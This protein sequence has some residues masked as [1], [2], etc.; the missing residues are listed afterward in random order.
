MRHPATAAHNLV[1]HHRYVRCGTA[2]AN[3]SKLEKQQRQL[4]QRSLASLISRTT[5][6]FVSGFLIP[7]QFIC[8]KARVKRPY[9]NT[10]NKVVLSTKSVA[11]SATLQIEHHQ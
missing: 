10:T 6:S 2:E 8:S 5:G 3:R 7:L 1:F 4:S 9:A 11:Y